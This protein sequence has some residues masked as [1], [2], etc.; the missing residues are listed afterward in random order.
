MTALGLVPGSN[1]PQEMPVG[2][3]QA[4]FSQGWSLT[5]ATLGLDNPSVTFMA[6]GGDWVQRKLSI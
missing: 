6:D 3:D 4:L 5:S 1:C 2:S